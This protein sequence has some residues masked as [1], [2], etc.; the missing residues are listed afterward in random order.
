[1][2][3]PWQRSFRHVQKICLAHL[4]TKTNV[5]ATFHELQSNTEEV[6]QS[7]RSFLDLLPF[8]CRYHG[9][10]ASDTSEK[11]VFHIFPPRSRCVP[12]FISFG[13]KT[14]E[15]VKSAR[16]FLDLLPLICR[17]H[18]NVLSG[19]VKKCVLHIYN[20]R[21]TSVPSFMEIGQKLRK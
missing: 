6:V 18:G 13:Q 14:E 21:H 2:P 12:H 1:M 17:Y 5:C 9:N 11:Y 3:L 15:V 4:P 19:T 10:A 7:A 16:S 8:I 20:Q